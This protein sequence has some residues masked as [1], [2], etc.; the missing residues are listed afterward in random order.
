MFRVILIPKAQKQLER[1]PKSHK[2]RIAAVIDGL[3]NDPYGGKKLEGDLAG[4]YAVR[5]W[6]YR[7]VYT[8]ERAIVTVKVVLIG[9]RQSVYERLRR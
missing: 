4:Y 7:V 6:P 2:A 5:V 9:H 1:V 3:A 8:I